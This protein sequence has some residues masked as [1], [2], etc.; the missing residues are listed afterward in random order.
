[1]IQVTPVITTKTV[2]SWVLL[3]VCPSF[4]IFKLSIKDEALLFKSLIMYS[5]S[6]LPFSIF[7]NFSKM[8]F[9]ALLRPPSCFLPLIWLELIERAKLWIYFICFSKFFKEFTKS[10]ITMLSLWKKMKF[11][12]EELLS[13][14][15]IFKNLICNL[16]S[17]FQNY[18]AF[19]FLKTWT[20]FS[21]S[22]FILLSPWKNYAFAYWLS[23]S[24]CWS[25]FW[26]VYAVFVITKL[27]ICR[28]KPNNNLIE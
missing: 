10:V 26:F 18:F 27:K 16:L 14:I 23:L 5:L 28:W 12:S 9:N 21:Q 8:D 6:N 3:S 4:L 25:I 11:F 13:Q 20:E 15:I 1:M 19:S 17:S 24:I 7:S 22:F 2:L